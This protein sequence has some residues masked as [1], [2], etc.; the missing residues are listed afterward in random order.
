[1]PNDSL[2]NS[3]PVPGAPDDI[4]PEGIVE[5]EQAPLEVPV[6]AADHAH[7]P[8]KDKVRPAELRVDDPALEGL[9][10]ARKEKELAPLVP[11]AEG[12]QHLTNIHDNQVLSR[13][14]RLL[15][16]G[17]GLKH[18]HHPDN[19]AKVLALAKDSGKVTNND[20][21]R[22]LGTSDRQASRYLN[23]LAKQGKLVKYGRFKQTF[24]KLP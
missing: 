17:R 21:E 11:A 20:V 5:P 24:Y 10:Q 14:R 1:M 7:L 15:H 3:A 12:E 4:R 22:L 9:L 16:V 18:Y 13:W 2:S 23:E 6:T 8:A 19:L